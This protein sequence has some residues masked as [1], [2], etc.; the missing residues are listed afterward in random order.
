MSLG[1][2]RDRYSQSP[3]CTAIDP[4][5]DLYE[6]QNS[7]ETLFLPPGQCV[8]HRGVQ[9]RAIFY[10]DAAWAG[11]QLQECDG[12]QVEREPS[13]EGQQPGLRVVLSRC[14]SLFQHGNDGVHRP[15]ACG[16]PHAQPEH[17]LHKRTIQSLLSRLQ[18]GP[19]LCLHPR[20]C[21]TRQRPQPVASRT[22]AS[23]IH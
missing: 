1:C 17:F 19:G 10:S 7:K 8:M 14:S 11:C 6:G 5:L 12:I 15:L 23:C 9:S 18:G 21:R 13:L 20:D 4:S 3:G 2:W 16:G 22:G